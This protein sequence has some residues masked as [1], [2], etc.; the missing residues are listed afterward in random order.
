M[1]DES[2][3]VVVKEGE[4]ERGVEGGEAHFWA[5]FR[6]RDVAK[7]EHGVGWA[8]KTISPVGMKNLKIR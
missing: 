5:A 1:G 7:A 2:L 4:R 8:N 6:T 3:K